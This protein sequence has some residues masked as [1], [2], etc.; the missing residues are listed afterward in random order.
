VIALLK[1]LGVLPDLTVLIEGE[2]ILNDG[3]S[4]VVYELC[5]A[6]M[7]EPATNGEY[8]GRGIQLVVGG[9]LLGA[10]M[11]AGTYAMLSYAKEPQEQTIIT[12]S[13]AYLCYFIAEATPVRVSGVLAVFVLGILM[14]AFR[15]SLITHEAE[16]TLHA[17]WAMLIQL[18]E[19]LIFLLAGAII[20]RRGFLS[21]S[22]VK[23]VPLSSRRNRHRAL[24]I[25]APRKVC[26]IL[27]ALANSLAPHKC[28]TLC[29][30][31]VPIMPLAIRRETR[32]GLCVVICRLWMAVSPLFCPPSHSRVCR[33]R[34]WNL[35]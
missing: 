4:I 2:S 5:Y 7:F 20:I 32:A 34:L 21:S 28:Q 13:A 15:R 6:V 12:I 19:T 3:T 31:I 22:T 29:T 11:F 16:H 24:Q 35:L 14:S 1:D 33:G 23:T 18:S 27:C 9:P 10:L 30:N 17:I 25:G 26:Q 8:I